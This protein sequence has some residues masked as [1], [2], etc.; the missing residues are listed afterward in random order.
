[1]NKVVNITPLLKSAGIV[2]DEISIVETPCMYPY[3]EKII[4][5]W[6]YFTAVGC[7]A[8]K[9]TLDRGQKIVTTAAIVGICSG[10]E[11]ITFTRVF[12]PALKKLIV[13]DVTQSISFEAARTSLKI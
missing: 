7:K 13:T 11:G 1:M 5:N 3:K 12:E 6:A 9:E 8:L 4:D 2:S 10:V